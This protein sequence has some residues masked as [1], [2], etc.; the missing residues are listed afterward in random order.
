MYGIEILE[1][2]HDNIIRFNQVVRKMCI[3]LMQGQDPDIAD[4]YSLVDFGRNY[5]DKQH[6]GKEEKI[7]FDRMLKEMG[8]LADKLTRNGMLVEHDLG[9]LHMKQL[10]EAITAYKEEASLDAKLDIIMNASGYV[11]L[12]NRH[13][14]KENTVVYTFAQKQLKPEVL[15][16]VNEQTEVFEKEAAQQGVQ[17]KYLALL[18]ELER[19][20]GQEIK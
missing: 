4:L 17:E 20:Y 13:I 10:E 19:K 2:E 12:L 1:K 16:D 6:H 9:R 8:P 18:A 11:D 14:E 5:A 15:A 7:L 3:L